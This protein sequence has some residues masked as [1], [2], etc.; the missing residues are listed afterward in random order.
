MEPIVISD[1]SEVDIQDVGEFQGLLDKPDVKGSNNKESSSNEN[2]FNEDNFED[3]K[4]DEKEDEKRHQK[5]DVS[6][7]IEDSYVNFEKYVLSDLGYV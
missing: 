2:S 5:K 1:D 3:E 7:A 6:Y 4:A